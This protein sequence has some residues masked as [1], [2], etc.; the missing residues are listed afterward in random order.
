[1]ASIPHVNTL[2]GKSH[3]FVHMCLFGIIT[4]SFFC[5]M[6]KMVVAVNL[7]INTILMRSTFK[8]VGENGKVGTVFILGKPSSTGRSQ[9]VL[10][11]A[12][13]VLEDLTGNSAI[14]FLR[15]KE[16][17]KYIK[18]PYLYQIRQD[19]RPVWVKHPDADVAAMFISIPEGFD[20]ALASTEILATDKVLE[21]YDIYPGRELKVLGFP[22]GLE[23]NLAGFPI[24][25]TGCIASFP[26]IPAHEL[27]TFLMDFRVFGGNS[28]GPVYFHAPSWQK[29]G[30]GDIGRGPE[31]QI[32][33][34]LVSEQKF[35]TEA[36]EAKDKCQL[37]IATV[38]HG[39]LIKET[40]NLLPPVPV[41][42]ALPLRELFFLSQLSF[43]NSSIGRLKE[44]VPKDSLAQVKSK[45]A[46][47]EIAPT[48]GNW[49]E[50]SE[51]V[52][53][54]AVKYSITSAVTVVS[55]PRSGARIKYQTVGQRVRKEVPT[56]AKQ[57]TTCVETLPIGRY[58]I[59][60]EREGRRTSDISHIY[61]IVK[62]EER[63]EI[64]ENAGSDEH[65]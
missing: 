36:Q 33:L 41:T 55:L 54:T 48:E 52:T 32:I 56:T 31:V 57:V 17:D 63:V 16:E 38:V 8:I 53:F 15:R 12:A 3:Q 40:V 34:G 59:W 7:D 42:S 28:G 44:K 29:R 19:G 39:A 10:V 47:W 18:V 64:I 6:P 21:D 13:H 2:N 37:S 1:M 46:D 24:L 11:T 58:H 51:A 5:L 23:S 27:K 25:R 43:L 26:L 65:E 45:T 4:L 49:M 50:I 35:M 61:E 60:A 14:I 20:I 30:S 9:Y 22:F 62:Q